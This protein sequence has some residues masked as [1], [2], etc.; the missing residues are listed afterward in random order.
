VS[1]LTGELMILFLLTTILHASITIA[2]Y[3]SQFQLDHYDLAGRMWENPEE[4]IDGKD[5]DGNGLADDI[6]GWNFADNN[7]VMFEPESN[8]Y[9][10]G[11][12]L[13]VEIRMKDRAG[14]TSTQEKE[15]LAANAEKYESLWRYY[16]GF[17]HGTASATNILSDTYRVRI[18]GLRNSSK[19]SLIPSNVTTVPTPI[20]GNATEEDILSFKNEYANEVFKI[21]N[22]AVQYAA[23]KKARVVQFG[24]LWQ[25]TASTGQNIKKLLE[26]RRGLTITDERAQLLA[27]EFYERL[28]EIGKDMF[29]SKPHMLFLLAS[30]NSSTN[31]DTTLSFPQDLPGE[32]VIVTGASD[33]SNLRALFSSYGKESVDILIPTIN[34]TESVPNNLTLVSSATSVSVA[35]MTNVVARV[36]EI[37]PDLTSLEVKKILFQ[38][39]NKYP[40]LIG[41]VKEGSII[42]RERAIEAARLSRFMSLSEALEKVYNV[43]P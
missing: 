14:L 35:L 29:S 1:S 2:S 40:H 37:N 36:L 7:G 11:I 13:Y 27:K 42:H 16:I 28:L 19:S 5:N 25:L 3:D 17:I 15:W 26:S 32:N 31:N 4:V 12:N 33:F 24:V 18:L 38:T 34:I 22:D 21:F 41:V 39:A 6:H 10:N 23:S 20:N 9:D 30:G 43:I 8:I